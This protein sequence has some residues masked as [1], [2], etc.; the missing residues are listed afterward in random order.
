MLFQEDSFNWK[1]IGSYIRR[2]T[3]AIEILMALESTIL[4]RG[5]DYFDES[6]I[7]I[8][9]RFSFTL[10]QL[11]QYWVQFSRWI[12]VL[13]H[14]P[15]LSYTTHH[16]MMAMLGD[17]WEE[18]CW[19]QHMGWPL[20]LLLCCRKNKGFMWAGTDQSKP[21]GIL[22]SIFLEVFLNCHGTKEKCLFCH[23]IPEYFRSWS[24]SSVRNVTKYSRNMAI[25]LVTLEL[26]DLILNR[27]KPVTVIQ[28]LTTNCRSPLKS[29]TR[30]ASNLCFN[31]NL[32]SILFQT[33]LEKKIF[34]FPISSLL[35]LLSQQASCF[36]GP[37]RGTKMPLPP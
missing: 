17:T 6:H 18:P 14:H 9:Y 10:L 20:S 34:S 5:A 25:E 32:Q 37:N 4:K 21:A 7:Q 23:N 29:H 15:K 28:S 3:I 8:H 13:Q 27:R 2:S 35:F 19:T 31:F 36:Q 26:A 1:R 22:P 16:L 33:F 30:N 11:C 24:W 12:C